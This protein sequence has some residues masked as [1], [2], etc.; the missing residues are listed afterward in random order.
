LQDRCT[1]AVSHA[2]RVARSDPASSANHE[3]RRAHDPAHVRG[4]FTTARQTVL[5]LHD[6]ERSDIRVFITRSFAAIV[7]SRPGLRLDG[8]PPSADMDTLV[9][10][11][12]VLSVFASTAMRFLDHPKQSPRSRLEHLL[13][14]KGRKIG[15]PYRFL[16]QLY[17]EVLQSA[18]ATQDDDDDEELCERVRTVMGA[19][20]AAQ[21]LLPVEALALLSQLELDVVQLAVDSLAALLL[22][23][24]GQPV[25]IFPFFPGLYSKR[26]ALRGPALVNLAYF[27]S[28]SACLWLPCSS[29]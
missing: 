10:H 27:N 7:Q 29:Q 8:W 28:L 22:T 6:L 18:V 19:V 13:A 5:R 23:G 12:D 25:R 14:R 3:S 9:D 20:I 11:S 17:S 21:H 2:E 26:E 15:S 24:Q 16:D 1:T 4:A